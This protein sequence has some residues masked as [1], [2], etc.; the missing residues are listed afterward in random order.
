MLLDDGILCVKQWYVFKWLY[1]VLEKILNS[2]HIISTPDIFLSEHYIYTKPL[3]H[4]RVEDSEDGRVFHV[5]ATPMYHLWC[6][7]SG[8]I[9]N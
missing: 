4:T 1:E 7:K 9:D 5:I 3:K 6:H 8:L 2:S